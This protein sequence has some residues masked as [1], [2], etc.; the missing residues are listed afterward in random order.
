LT[1]RGER[2]R[3]SGPVEREVSQRSL[4]HRV[5]TSS[6]ARAAVVE[7]AKAYRHRAKVSEQIQARQQ[8]LPK[9]ICDIAWRARIDAAA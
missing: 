8:Q 1:G 2:M 7:A 6:P 4:P 3:A 5:E 9:E